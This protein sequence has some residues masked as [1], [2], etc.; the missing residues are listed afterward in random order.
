MQA[1][2]NTTAQPEVPVTQV[3]VQL[4][5]LDP[6]S[7]TVQGNIDDPGFMET[8]VNQVLR[9]YKENEVYV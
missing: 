5:D 2:S 6:M 4:F 8:V 7:L 9:Q 1:N 3:N